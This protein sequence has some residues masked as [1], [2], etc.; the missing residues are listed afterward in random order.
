MSLLGVSPKKLTDVPF[1]VRL[2]AA[3]CKDFKS[4]SLREKCP[5][6]EL[7]S[8]NAGKCGPEKFQMRTL[9]TQGMTKDLDNFIKILISQFFK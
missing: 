5:Y 4:L 1:S 6:A 9:S 3:L 2:I 7:F 8:P